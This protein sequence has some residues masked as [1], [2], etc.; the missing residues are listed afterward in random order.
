[1][2]FTAGKSGPAVEFQRYVGLPVNS[3]SGKKHR[4]QSAD[5]CT[6]NAFS[7]RKTVISISDVHIRDALSSNIQNTQFALVVG[8][9]TIG[10]SG[11]V[12]N[13]DL[14]SSSS[15]RFRSAEFMFDIEYNLPAVL[16]LNE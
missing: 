12:R 7:A 5:P 10:T 14:T 6:A 15:A 4:E 13:T 16:V 11:D 3:G 1:M 2:F 9:R 8:E